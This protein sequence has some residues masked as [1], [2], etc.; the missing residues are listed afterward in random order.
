MIGV[1]NQTILERVLT[2]KGYSC[3]KNWKKYRDSDVFDFEINNRKYDVK[4]THIYSR[5]NQEWE[6]ED[7]TPELL[8]SNKS[9]GGP[10][11]KHFF[12]MMVPIS[13]LTIDKMKD[14]YIFGIA[15]SFDDIRKIEPKI[16]DNGFWCSVPF[17]KAFYFFH[18]VPSIRAREKNGQGFKVKITWKNPQQRFNDNSRAVVFTL[19]GEWDEKKQFE[20]LKLNP[21]E[22]TSSVNEFSSLS[23]LKIDHP[24]LLDHN[25]E[26]IISV[27]NYFDQ[28]VP[29]S[30]NPKINL[31]DSNFEWVL[32]KNS[33][34]NL[35]V[36]QDYKVY[37]V[38]YI[39]F[40]EFA[41]VFKDY[42]SYFIPLP[43]NMDVNQEGR[44]NNRFEK[45]LRSFDKKRA[46]A[47]EKGIPIPWPEFVPLM[48]I[49]TRTVKAGILLAAMAGPRPIG[50]ACYYYPPY[51]FQETA[52]YVLPKDLYIIDSIP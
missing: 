50:A 4:T 41:S 42:N 11:W 33:F 23:C 36:P 13:Q 12:P 10:E 21:R 20:D 26:F 47:I 44:V 34:V 7:F 15:E 2:T 29:K 17:A 27:E 6:R 43:R 24:A 40:Q 16:S 39:P 37:W 1:L 48:D 5:Y 18:S 31:N 49:K 8:I 32:N 19:F 9:Y 14:S 38:G 25:D 35:K 3:S 22:E 45:R 46:K 30:T 52:I 51:A 28:H